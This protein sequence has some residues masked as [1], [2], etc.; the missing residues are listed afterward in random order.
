MILIEKYVVSIEI[1]ERGELKTEGGGEEEEEGWGG[2]VR[3]ERI[4]ASASTKGGR[5]ASA[6]GN[7]TRESVSVCETRRRET[8]GV[9]AGWIIIVLVILR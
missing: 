4:R 6:V 5:K 2:D 8:E 3:D 9:R 1:F 7:S